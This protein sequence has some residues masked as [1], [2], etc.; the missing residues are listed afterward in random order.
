MGDFACA[1]QVAQKQ[2]LVGGGVR[3]VLDAVVRAVDE[4]VF[5]KPVAEDGVDPG[6]ARRK[7]FPNANAGLE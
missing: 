4:G 7:F 6:C 3:H 5:H 1:E 2:G